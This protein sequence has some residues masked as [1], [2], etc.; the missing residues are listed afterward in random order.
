MPELTD[1]D[2]KLVAE[3][4][5]L[6]KERRH[7]IVGLLKQIEGIFLT[8]IRENGKLSSLVHSA[9]S[10][11]KDEQHLEEKLF[12]KILD[13]KESGNLYDVTHENFFYK[14]TDLGG[15]RMMHLHP[16]QM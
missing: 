4:I 3:L 16:R 14:V 7:K 15:F 13:G 12:R 2:R 9:K 11:V 10:R 6:F 5:A 1:A 8:E